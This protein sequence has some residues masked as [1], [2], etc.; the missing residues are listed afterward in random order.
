MRRKPSVLWGVYRRICI[1]ILLYT[2]HT[3]QGTLHPHLHHLQMHQLSHLHDVFPDLRSSASTW[4]V[5]KKNKKTLMCQKL[6]PTLDWKS[7]TRMHGSQNTGKRTQPYWPQSLC[8]E[9]VQGTLCSP[10]LNRLGMTI[11]CFMYSSFGKMHTPSS[12]SSA[13]T[14]R[15]T[16]IKDIKH[17]MCIRVDWCNWLI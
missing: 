16:K 8:L 1:Q 4:R 6:S 9:F 2:P 17:V 3:L 12:V 13:E 10:Q 15:S 7:R 14:R 11:D 5:W